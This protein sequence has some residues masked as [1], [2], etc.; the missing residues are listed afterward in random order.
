MKTIV[1]LSTPMGRSA[2]AVVRMSGD[3]SI[4]IASQIF[5]P[6]PQNA[7]TLRVGSLVCHHFVEKAMCVFFRAPHSYTG[8]DMVEFHCHGGTA[9]CAEV[10]DQCIKHGA[11][12]AQNGEFSKRAFLNG[13]QNLTNAEG[14]IEMIDAETAS[15]VKAGSNLLDNKLGKM[16]TQLQDELTDVISQTEVALD[17]PEEDLELPTAADLSRKLKDVSAKLGKLLATVET[18]K[19]VKY[20]INVAIIGKP[21][22]GK[23]SLLNA[24]LNSDRAIV[25][26]IAGTTR[27]TLRESLNYK[28]TRFNFVDTAGLRKSD[29]PIEAEGVRRAE[30]AVTEAD[31]VLFVVDETSAD[32]SFDK[33]GVR[34]IKVFNKC[35]EGYVRAKDLSQNEIDVSA[36]SGHNVEKLKEKI[37]DMFRVGDVCGSDVVLTNARHVECLDRAKK[38]VDETVTLTCGATLDCVATTLKE[39]WEALGE[40]TGTTANEEIIDRI[41]SKFCL[42]K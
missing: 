33:E 6:M 3:E 1:A 4:A 34:V 11:R 41:Y 21:N 5:S 38:A 9:I 10:I 42:G 12:M 13:K 39:A 18:G 29:D 36:K 14:I 31:V 37:Y 17:Y 28:D 19:I 20:G 7:N 25:S 30:K 26:D 16:T 40:I 32:Q 15:A 23:S 27:D 22:V 2:I 24:M 35:D 8:E